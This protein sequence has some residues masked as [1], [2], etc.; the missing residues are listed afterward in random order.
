MTDNRPPFVEPYH[1]NENR[2][3]IFTT[4][5]DSLNLAHRPLMVFSDLEK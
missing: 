4:A 1:N 5:N 2:F 3:V